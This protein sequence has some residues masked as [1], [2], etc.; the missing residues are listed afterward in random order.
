[1]KSVIT[2][3]TGAIISA[4]T[5]FNLYANPTPDILAN[6]NQAAEG[7]EALVETVYDQLNALIKEQG[8]KPLS[9]V[10]LGSTQTL[11][12]RDAFMPWN[13]M[14]YTEQGLATIAKAVA[15]ID[16][17]PQDINQQ[18]RIQGLPEAYLTQAMAAVTYT[19]LPDFFNHFERGYDLYLQLLNDPRFAQQ[20][21]AATAW[22]YHTGIAAALKSEDLTQAK[23][24]LS[25]MAHADSTHP[26]TQAAQ[27]LIAH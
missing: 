14:K 21:F 13:K 4:T 2:L 27:A 8:A 6:Y 7:N 25:V 3:L 23:E 10:Y 26:Q 24:W 18:Q 22:V 5:S 9:L 17:L 12:G 19:S 1:M 20:P 11:Q 16:S 15:L